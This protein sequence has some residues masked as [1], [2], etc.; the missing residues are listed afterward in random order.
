MRIRV[1]A[2][3]RESMKLKNLTA[4]LMT[5]MMTITMV[6][7]GSTAPE[8]A[9]AE[10]PAQ[11]EVETETETETA[12]ETETETQVQTEVETETETKDLL[13]PV[14]QRVEHLDEL[15]LKKG[16]GCGFRRY[17]YRQYLRCFTESRAVPP[18]RRD[19]KW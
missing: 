12:V 7:C 1:C 3:G 8:A 2:E 5:A 19:G 14:C 18:D 4:V 13:L 9:P 15:L 16:K 11:T 17:L 10:T 6:G